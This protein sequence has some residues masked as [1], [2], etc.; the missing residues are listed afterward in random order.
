[1]QMLCMFDGNDEDIGGGG[2][3]RVYGV[4]VTAERRTSNEA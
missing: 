4:V 3:C 2:G 1:M